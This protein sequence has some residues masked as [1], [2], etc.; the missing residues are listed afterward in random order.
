[1]K[2]TGKN[3][4]GRRIQSRRILTGLNVNDF[5][6]VEVFEVN[7]KEYK[8]NNKNGGEMRMKRIEW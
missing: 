1:M 3:I 8:T 6:H 2:T 7:I 4:R 5:A